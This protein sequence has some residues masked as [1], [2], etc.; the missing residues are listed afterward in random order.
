MLNGRFGNSDNHGRNTALLKKPDSIRLAPISD[1]AP[2]NADPEGTMR[3]SQW[4][5]PL[6][7]GFRF[8]G[9]AMA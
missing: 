4:G 1:F 7:E 2:M 9:R 8:N 5:A 3:L 6:E